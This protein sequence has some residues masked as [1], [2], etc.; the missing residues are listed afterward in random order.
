MT[1]A[2]IVLAVGALAAASCGTR[3]AASSAPP[4][5]LDADA[6]DGAAAERPSGDAPVVDARVADA[7]P[8][9]EAGP[10]MAG[11]CPGTTPPTGYRLCRT[12]ED[13]GSAAF[14]RCALEYMTPQ[15]CGACNM[16]KHTCN[17]DADCGPTDRCETYSLPC[18]CTFGTNTRCVPR[19]TA[20]S[21]PQ[22]QR[23][24]A[25]GTCELIPCTDGYD[26][27][28]QALCAPT[29]AGHL[30][31]GCAYRTCREDGFTCPAGTA[32]WPAVGD[33][34]GCG[35]VRCDR[36]GAPCP[37]N[38]RCDP[39]AGGNGCRVKSC[40]ADADCDCGACIEKLCQ[41]RLFICSPVGVAATP[42]PG[43]GL[44]L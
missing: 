15:G 29:R 44:G 25:A 37:M 27:G 18:T 28:P 35:A 32:C 21:C 12:V 3:N 14:N 42:R 8:P 1:G 34:H 11:I 36:G 43:S 10:L 16:A 30:P 31:N 33:E 9:G 2:R 26:C 22:G 17:T 39:G 13:C 23:C 5:D 24:N 4:P 20:T 40:T 41:P 6:P 38:S 7:K 19:C